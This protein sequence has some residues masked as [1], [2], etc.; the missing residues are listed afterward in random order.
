MAVGYFCGGMILAFF[1]RRASGAFSQEDMHRTLARDVLRAFVAQRAGVDAGQQVLARA[2]QH[3]SHGEVQL[4]DEALAQVLADGRDAA[5]DPDIAPG[6]GLL[7]LV[8][9]RADA[10]RHEAE[11]GPA[12]HAKRRARMVREDEYRR[13][14]RRLLA[15]PA[16]P[17]LVRPWA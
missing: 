13:V 14:V 1:H 3:G 2:Q 8:Q 7:R 9:R 12:L 11:L 6:R 4:V 15:P 10:V 5:P 17:A 16:F